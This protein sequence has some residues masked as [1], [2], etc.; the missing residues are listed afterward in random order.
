M[1]PG[2]ESLRRRLMWVELVVGSPLLQGAFIRVVR[3]SLLLKTQHFQIPILSGT[4]GHASTSS[5]ENL[6]VLKRTPKCSVDKQISYNNYNLFKTAIIA[7]TV[8]FEK[9]YQCDLEDLR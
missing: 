7:I 5:F 2:F 1:W 4:H 9:S 3:F 6:G 8:Q